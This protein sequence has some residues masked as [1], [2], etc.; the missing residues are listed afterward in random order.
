MKL[1]KKINKKK[2]WSVLIS[3]THDP[4]HEPEAPYRKKIWNSNLNKS[5][6]E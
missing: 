1:K 6:I 4:G 3:Q 5:N 2:C